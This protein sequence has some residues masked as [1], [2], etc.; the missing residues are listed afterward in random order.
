MN[1]IFTMSAEEFGN[2]QKVPS[3]NALLKNYDVSP[4]SDNLETLGF[5]KK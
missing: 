1:L 2:A 5:Y 4:M 3:M